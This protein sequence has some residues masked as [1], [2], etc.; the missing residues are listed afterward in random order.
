MMRKS[1]LPVLLAV[2]SLG[3]AACAADPAESGGTESG[4]SE[5]VAATGFDI[6]KVQKV[7]EIANMVPAAIADSG[8]LK[9]TSDTTYPP[10]EFLA[11]DGQT[12]T[13]YDVD[14]VNA[15][16][17]VMG[18]KGE[19]STSVF[20][21]IIPSVGTKFDVS[22]SSFTIT[23][24]RSEQI[25][26]VSY[27]KAGSSFAVPAGNPA[28]FSVDEL[29]GRVIGVQ[30]GTTQ[31]DFL[32]AA[33]EECVAADQEPIDIKPHDL[34]S[35]VTTKVAGGQYDAMAAD[36]PVIDWAVVM[37]GKQIEQV[38]EVFD[39]AP[40][41]ILVSKDDPELT[42]AVQAAL[43]HLMDEGYLEEILAVYGAEGS[44]LKTSE[45]NPVE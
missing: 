17:A 9:N 27:L 32:T 34:Q 18:L 43:Q 24:E 7:D 42:A 33:S 23:P 4:Q 39:S 36:S 29:C 28:G 40:Q 37:T 11:D 12:P 5:A 41:G 6:S 2:A 19:T 21:T 1:I 26:M 3:L 30:T 14:I 13:G 22:A 35:D 25:N 10:A 15:I 45:I 38:G 20:D 44:A 8:V 31:L 16:A